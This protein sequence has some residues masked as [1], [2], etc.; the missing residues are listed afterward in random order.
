MLG[1]EPPRALPRQHQAAI[2]CP[3]R[4]MSR[5]GRFVSLALTGALVVAV[6]V[7]FAAG[8]AHAQ[9]PRRGT[10]PTSS[11]FL[12]EEWRLRGVVLAEPARVAILQHGTNS[13]LQF[14]RVGDVVERGVAV[15]SIAADRVVLDADGRSVILRLAH[16][17]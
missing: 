12:A 3:G 17:S 9:A 4:L 2:A 13:R 16:G 6:S 14:L 5:P 8:D 15:A 1:Q 7:V 11:Q 10:P